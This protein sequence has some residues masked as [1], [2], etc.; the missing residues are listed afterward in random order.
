MDI[1]PLIERCYDHAYVV[2]TLTAL[3]RT[4]ADVPSGQN[5]IEPTD[6][7]LTYYVRRVVRP[8]FE[9]LDLGP[10]EVDDL[11]NLVCT[12]GSGESP[13]LLVMG[14]TTAQHGHET[15]AALEGAVGNGRAYGFD[16]EC[17]FGRGTGQNKGALASVL[18]ALRIIADAA[19]ALR[20]TLI[21]V[22][23]AESQSSHRC[24]EHLFDH[25]RVSADAGWLAI[26]VPKIATGHRG[27]VDIHVTVEGEAGHSSQPALARNAIWGLYEALARVA[28]IQRRLTATH[29][30][31]GGE[32][33][34]PYKLVTYPIAPHTM[35]SEAA[36]TLDRRL[37]P[38]TDPDAAVEQVRRALEGISGYRV[39]VR[40]GVYHRAYQVSPDLPQVRALATAYRAI[41]GEDPEIG[42]VPYAFDAGYANFRGVPTVM[43]GPST[44]H[45][46]QHGRTVLATELIP[47]SEVRDFTKVYAHAILSLLAQAPAPGA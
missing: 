35:P 17:V 45:R 15:D 44:R 7:K 25:G 28:S 11:N 10:V 27:R 31:L 41:R 18:G 46:G 13:R 20:G 1:L 40:R 12:I 30:E 23:N 36:F 16:E 22:V 9:R 38:G 37:L 32:Q 3:A 24:S 14:Y 2:D 4:P 39:A 47:I 19:A 8:M 42:S 21:V 33:L 26:G 6:P 34:E 29:P 5:E 43:F